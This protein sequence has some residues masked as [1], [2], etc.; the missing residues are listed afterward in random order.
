MKNKYRSIDQ[1]LDEYLQNPE[2]A[3]SFLN[4][5]LLDEDI[6]AFK[7]SL[8]DVIRVHGNISDLAKKAHISRTTL[9]NIMRG[10]GQVEVG[11]ILK[12]LHALGFNLTVTKR[13]QAAA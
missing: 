2:F 8:K 4:Q 5:A 3:I 11:T 10:E 12:L 1:L 9:Y 7:L 6:E 13:E